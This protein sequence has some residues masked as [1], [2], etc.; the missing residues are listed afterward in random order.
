[1]RSVRNVFSSQSG[2]QPKTSNLRPAW[3]LNS[4]GRMRRNWVDTGVPSS[5]VSGVFL[6][7]EPRK[8]YKFQIKTQISLLKKITIIVSEILCAVSYIPISCVVFPIYPIQAVLDF[9][10]G[11]PVF[12]I[13]T[14]LDYNP[15]YF[16]GQTQVHLDP[17]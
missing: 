15:C 7:T 1:M 8:N 9:K 5:W 3:L 13:T 10:F 6:S 16:P 2:V 14:T 17:A 12:T 4:S 11:N